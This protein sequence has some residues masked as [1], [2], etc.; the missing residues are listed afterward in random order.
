M[1]VK[2]LEIAVVLVVMTIGVVLFYKVKRVEDQYRNP[3]GP[4]GDSIPAE[5]PDEANRIVHASGLSIIAPQNWDQIRDR[6]PDVEFLCIAARNRQLHK[7]LRSFITISEADQ[8]TPATLSDYVAVAFQG[9]S[10]YECL[11]VDREYSFDDGARSSYSLYVNAEGRW[12][13]IEWRVAETIR[14]MPPQ[15]KEYLDTIKLPPA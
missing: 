1:K 2:P 4:A 13:Y 14:E 11:R 5:S 12:W 10:A 6:G 9:S 8:P 3:K 15:I 7:R